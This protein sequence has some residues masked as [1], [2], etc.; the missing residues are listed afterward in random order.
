MKEA[1]PLIDYMGIFRTPKLSL[2]REKFQFRV[3][4]L[5]LSTTVKSRQLRELQPLSQT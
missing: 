1:T 4:R 5:G 3:H 2:G